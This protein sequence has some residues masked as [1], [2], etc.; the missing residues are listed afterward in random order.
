MLPQFAS[1]QSQDFPIPS[2][3]KAILESFEKPLH[4]VVGGVAPGGGVGVGIGYATPKSQDWFRNASTM[5]TVSRFWSVEGETG[6]QTQRSRIGIFGEVRH[7][8]RLDFFGVGPDSLRT[9]RTDFRL[10]ETTAGAR[11]WIR[12]GPSVRTGGYAEFY[13]PSLGNGTSPSLP[14]IEQIFE[15]DSVPGLNDD[16]AFSRYRAFVDFTHPT[17]ASPVA[18]GEGQPF[19]GVYQ[20]AVE[21]VRDHDSGRYNFQRVEVEVKQRIPGIRAAQRLTLHGLVAITNAAGVVPY[22]MQ[23]TLGGGGGL[24]AFRP[25]TIGTDG[26]RATL[27]SY[28]NYRFRDRDVFLMQAEYRI[29]VHRY[30][31]ATVFYDA[32]QVAERASDLFDGI[33]QGT[34]FSLAY[35]HKGADVV[36][37]DLGYGSGEGVHYFWTFA[38]PR[39]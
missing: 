27:R 29:P 5:V 1:A 12:L 23:Y 15:P 33:K 6:R 28:Q 19:L 17:S 35:N 25:D 7:M 39:F 8:S 18:P 11:G 16:P 9:N 2:A 24:S 4:P 38:G 37:F 14:S 10:R 21:A 13:L 20:L 36:R 30:V 32:G 26:T 22:Y 34:G 31:S 3:A